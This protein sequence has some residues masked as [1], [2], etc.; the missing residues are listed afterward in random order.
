M[1]PA[2]KCILSCLVCSVE[3]TASTTDLR[4]G[5]SRNRRYAR[6]FLNVVAD[7]HD[8]G[9]SQPNFCSKNVLDLLVL[10]ALHAR[11][12]KGLESL[13]TDLFF[14]HFDCKVT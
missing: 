11:S 4:V 5:G 3:R 10:H 6:L 7:V 13:E 8:V 9:R 2:S 12:P 1:G 14:Y